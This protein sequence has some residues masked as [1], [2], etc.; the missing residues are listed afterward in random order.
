MADALDA[1]A[2]ERLGIVAHHLFA[3]R[4]SSGVFLRVDTL[5]EKQLSKAY[6]DLRK[7]KQSESTEAE[8]LVKESQAI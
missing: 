1:P 2:A 8:G 6:A 5:D 4:Q 7:Q 3:R